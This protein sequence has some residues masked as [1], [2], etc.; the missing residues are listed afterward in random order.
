MKS[1]ANRPKQGSAAVGSKSRRSVAARAGSGSTIAE[2][3]HKRHSLVSVTGRDLAVD[4][5]PTDPKGRP[6][7]LVRPFRPPETRSPARSAQPRIRRRIKTVHRRCGRPG[8]GPASHTQSS[9]GGAR[10][11]SGS[12]GRGGL[13]GQHGRGKEVA[14]W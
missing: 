4:P 1:D 14:G 8:V 2:G 7:R 3:C 13:H 5:G 9:V 10:P 6:C 12:L 11:G